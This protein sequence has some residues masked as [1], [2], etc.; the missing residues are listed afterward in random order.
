MQERDFLFCRYVDLKNADYV[1]YGS[2]SQQVD[3]I[4]RKMHAMQV[5]G[6][7]FRNFSFNSDIEKQPT[8]SWTG[9]NKLLYQSKG[10]DVS[11][12]EIQV[13][14]RDQGATRVFLQLVQKIRKS[15]VVVVMFCP[16]FFVLR[17]MVL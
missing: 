8:G 12:P 10:L 13:A 11:N 6:L 17:S 7:D 15:F 3:R 14:K 16:R 5:T 4:G 2:I 9:K 1:N